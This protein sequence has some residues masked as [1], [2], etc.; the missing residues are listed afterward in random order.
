MLLKRNPSPGTLAM[1]FWSEMRVR[2]YIMRQEVSPAEHCF[3]FSSLYYARDTSR[4][5]HSAQ[6]SPSTPICSQR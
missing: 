5:S 2:G 4:Q 6:S 3:N 1:I